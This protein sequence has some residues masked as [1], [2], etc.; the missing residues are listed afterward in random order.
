MLGITSLLLTLASIFHYSSFSSPKVKYR[1]LEVVL[2]TRPVKVGEIV[3][4]LSIW[5][6]GEKVRR[7]EEVGEQVREK[8]DLV[9]IGDSR[10][11]TCTV[12]SKDSLT[13]EDEREGRYTVHTVGSQLIL[14]VAAP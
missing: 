1:C 4:G 12:A 6:Q 14:H 9:Q 10:H 7:M 13:R 8:S 11:Q 5:R 3:D 2:G